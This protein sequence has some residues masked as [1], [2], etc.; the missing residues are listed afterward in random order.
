MI[1]ILFYILFSVTFSA[2][3]QEIDVN[4]QKFLKTIYDDFPT[5]SVAEASKKLKNSN[6]IFLDSREKNE[7]IVSHIPGAIWIGFEDFNETRFKNISK[8]KTIIIYCSVG[9]RSQSIG[10]KLK[11]IGYKNI[12]NLYGGLFQWVNDEKIIVD[13]NESPTKNIHGYNKTWSK[14]IKKGIVVY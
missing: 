10:K 6:Y 4:Y 3:S 9:A 11:K 12:F 8:K 2:F 14:W 1:K 7:F 5:I 13:E